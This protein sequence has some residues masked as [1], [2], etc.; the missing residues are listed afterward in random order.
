MI[1]LLRCYFCPTIFRKYSMSFEKFSW[2][3][4]RKSLSISRKSWGISQKSAPIAKMSRGRGRDKDASWSP[5]S[6]KFGSSEVR[7]FSVIIKKINYLY[8]YVTEI[9]NFRSSELLNFFFIL[10][11]ST[12]GGLVCGLSSEKKLG[13]SS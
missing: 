11:L 12:T 8:I 7:I 10:R 6:E 9:R 2:S 13:L 1:T 3:I 5:D 4:S